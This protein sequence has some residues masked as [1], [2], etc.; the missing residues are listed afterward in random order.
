MQPEPITEIGQLN[1]LLGYIE[2]ALD[3]TP[4]K[5]DLRALHYATG[6]ALGHASEHSFESLSDE[7]KEVIEGFA[8]ARQQIEDMF[9]DQSTEAE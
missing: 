5:A 9:L 3:G 6:K 8:T 1:D 2:L 7:D 4:D